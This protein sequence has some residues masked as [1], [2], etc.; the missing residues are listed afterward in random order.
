LEAIQL[1]DQSISFG[2]QNIHNPFLDFIMP[3]I[4]LISDG[5]IIWMVFGAALCIP[6]RYR[7]Y[8]I[9]VFFAIGLSYVVGSMI[10]K[11]LVAR[12]RP[13]DLFPNVPLLTD[14]PDGFSFPSGHTIAAFAGA[15]VIWMANW[16]FGIPALVLAALVGFSRIYLFAH[17]LTDTLAGA[18]LGILCAIAMAL[19]FRLALFLFRRI[20][21]DKRG[22]HRGKH[23]DI[24]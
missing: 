10:L 16:R 21:G 3:I 15:T 11:P 23:Y 9:M 19:L 18:V 22:R 2:L 4:S 1:W 8:G 6:R 5:G 14:K 12:P 13:C 20:R 17:F 7:K 24:S